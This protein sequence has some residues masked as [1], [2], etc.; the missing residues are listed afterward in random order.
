MFFCWRGRLVSDLLGSSFGVVHFGRPAFHVAGVFSSFVY[1][2]K[3][4]EGWGKTVLALYSEQTVFPLRVFGPS[5]L[6]EV[7]F[8]RRGRGGA[9][10]LPGEGGG[11]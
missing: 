10:V 4:A 1:F 6:Y 9:S 11:E 2:L 3:L 5:M 7:L 8:G